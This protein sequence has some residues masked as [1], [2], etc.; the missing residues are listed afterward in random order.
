M[1]IIKDNNKFEFV[2]HPK[3]RLDTSLLK[4]PKYKDTALPRAK[5]L[6]N[7]LCY[8][9]NSLDLLSLYLFPI[10]LLAFNKLLLLLF[11]NKVDPCELF[12]LKTL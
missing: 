11:L 3:L 1:P 12:E 8:N 2:Y 4:P 5:L 7:Y 10:Y 6:Y 9:N